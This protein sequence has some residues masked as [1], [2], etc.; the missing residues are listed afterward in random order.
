MGGVLQSGP[1][2]AMNRLATTRITILHT[3]DWHS[4]IEPF[5]RDGGQ[6][7]GQGGA[8]ARVLMIESIRKESEHVLLLDAGDIFQGTPYFNYFGGEPE[9]KLM[10]LMGYDAVTLGNHDF[11]NGIDGIMKQLPHAGFSMLNAN[12]DFTGTPLKD[13]VKPYQ[14]FRKG[15][16]RIGVFGIGI[17]LKGLVPNA[18]YGSIKYLDPIQHAQEMA[19]HLRTAEHCHLVICLSH[20]GYKYAHQKVSDISLAAATEGIDLIIGGHTH[21]FLDE[22]VSVTNRM[23][24]SVLINQV[25]WA[26]VRLGRID[27]DFNPFSGEVNKALSE[28]RKIENEVG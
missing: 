9:Y 26:G 8:A 7:S 13:I 16:V 5:E 18:L 3:N 10:T 28:V 4:R 14:I 23:G 6:L 24:Q 25:G 19:M 15:P 1:L 2:G 20:L 17:E 11:D 21:T 27:F 22:P 12:Y